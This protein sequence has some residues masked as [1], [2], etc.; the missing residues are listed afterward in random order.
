MQYLSLIKKIFPFLLLII[1]IP[2]IS[3]CDN[4]AFGTHADSLFLVNEHLEIFYDLKSPS[5][6]YFLPYVLEEISGLSFHEPNAILAVDDET[7]RVFEY[8]LIKRDIIHSMTF[9][10]PDDFEG[11]E[12]V[13]STIYVLKS[14][15]DLFEFRYDSNKKPKAIK[16][17]NS[18]GKKNDTEGLAY[19]PVSQRLLI[20]CKEKGEINDNGAKGR[21][22]YAFD[23]N[24]KRLIDTPI[25]EISAVSL[26][27]FWERNRDFEYEI[28]RIKFKPSAIAFNP[29]DKSYYI[30]SSVGKLLVVINQKSQIIGTYPISPRVLGQPEG[31]CFSSSGDMYI[32]SEGEG[33]RGYILKFEMNKR[34][35]K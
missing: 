2:S 16:H 8:D 26:E 4:R 11:V 1:I 33:D 15:G 31:L 5:E 24:Q 7:G 35:I 27:K 14:D 28:E 29:I 17:E 13:D 12:L 23:L 18:L 22:I 25:A 20:A 19:D 32:S 21:A 34:S 10:S 9:H 3:S 30:L 6:K